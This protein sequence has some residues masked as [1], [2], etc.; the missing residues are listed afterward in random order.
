[1]PTFQYGSGAV[2]AAKVV[3]VKDAVVNGSD[4]KFTVDQAANT[5]LS[6]VFIRVI[7]AVALDAAGKVGIGIG[8]AEG[9]TDVFGDDNIFCAS[10]ATDIPANAVYQIASKDLVQSPAS[11]APSAVK[12]Y[13]AEARKLH[14]FIDNPSVAVDKAGT[15]EVHFLFTHLA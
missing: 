4:T 15:F 7:D 9:E 8:D 13:T 3:T 1:M 11:S 14:A 5:F 10:T 2:T 6:G 12:G